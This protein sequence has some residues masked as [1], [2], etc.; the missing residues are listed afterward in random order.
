[1][2]AAVDRRPDPR[3]RRGPDAVRPALRRVGRGRLGAALLVARRT[4]SPA[5]RRAACSASRPRPTLVMQR[6]GV[7]FWDTGFG[8]LLVINLVL[9]FFDRRTSR[10]AA[11]IGG[12]DRRPARGRGDAAGAQGRTAR[13]RLSSARRS[14]A[15]PSS[16]VALVGRGPSSRRSARPAAAT[17]TSSTAPVSSS[18]TS[19]KPHC[20]AS[21]ARPSHGPVA[22][23]SSPA[24]SV[25][26]RRPVEV[27]AAAPDREQVE[28]GVVA[29]LRAAPRPRRRARCP[30]AIGYCTNDLVGLAERDREDRVHL[31]VLLDEPHQLL[32]G[33]A[34][35]LGRRAEVQQAAQ[36]RRVDRLRAGAQHPELELLAHLVEP[37]LELASPARRGPGRCSSSA[38]VREADRGLGDVLHLDEHVDG[39]VEVGDRGVLLDRRPAATRAR[40]RARAPRRC[41]RAR[42]AGSATSSGSRML[43]AVGIDEPLAAAPDRDDAH[44]DLHRQ[45]DVVERAVRERGVARARARGATP[46]R[47]RRGRRRAPAGCRGG[48]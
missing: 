25:M 27:A 5:A 29:D 44:A 14:S 21:A 17:G 11:H 26:R 20:S 13:A 4:R 33:V 45:L 10:S 19:R 16:C 36:P 31:L 46:L 28:A 42:R 38:R 8:P 35:L 48:A 41:P 37:V 30:R 22:R 24:A 43:V 1:M 15:S 3:A 18:S 23:I 12:V 34:D 9:D 32:R 47:R 2:L 39:A 6:Q 7:R 40:P